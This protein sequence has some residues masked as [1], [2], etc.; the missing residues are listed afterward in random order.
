MAKKGATR[1]RGAKTV[2]ASVLTK[3]DADRFEKSAT[4]WGKKAARTKK[5]ARK[6]LV[7]LGIVTPKG[8]LTKKYG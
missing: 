2:A 4:A 8:R 5:S 6:T 7:S 1:K 3:E